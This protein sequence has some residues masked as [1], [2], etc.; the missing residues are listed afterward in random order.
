MC[1]RFLSSLPHKYSCWHSPVDQDV[2][3]G[4][5]TLLLTPWFLTCEQ[6][7]GTMNFW[8][9]NRLDHYGVNGWE[10]NV[11]SD[12]PIRLPV[13]VIHVIQPCAPELNRSLNLLLVSEW[14]SVI[15]FRPLCPSWIY[16]PMD[17]ATPL[18]AGQVSCRSPATSVVF[19]TPDPSLVISH[20]VKQAQNWSWLCSLGSVCDVFQ[21]Q[22]SGPWA[23]QT[24]E[25]RISACQSHLSTDW[26][27][28]SWF[29]SFTPVGPKAF[30]HTITGVI[31]SLKVAWNWF[32][33]SQ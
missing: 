4:E 18:P 27:A 16:L 7:T 32:N 11:F 29:L 19:I 5:Q 20:L 24:P 9:G 17:W 30:S 31:L 23:W 28:L 1:H 26:V 6:I 33:C 8:R 12:L 25:G 14:A 15:C 10:A 13:R 22:L 3:V 2:S 21:I